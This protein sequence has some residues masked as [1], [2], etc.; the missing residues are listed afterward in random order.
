MSETGSDNSRDNGTDADPQAG[1]AGGFLRRRASW[2]PWIGLIVLVVFLQWPMLKGTFYKYSGIEAPAS[3]IAWRSNFEAAMAE[4]RETNTP[5]LVDFSASWC[6]PC[7]VMK[8]EVWPDLRVREAIEGRYIPVIMDVDAPAN[9][10][11]AQRF[12]IQAV[13]TILV[14]SPSGE[15]ARRGA[16]MSAGDLVEFLQNGASSPDASPS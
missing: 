8:H 9:Q 16:Y 12:E 15:V 2:L 10:P 3:G 13:P 4:A 11:V 6:P 1:G 14:V 7:Q 5:L